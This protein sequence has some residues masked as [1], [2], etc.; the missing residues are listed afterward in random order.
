MVQVQEVQAVFGQ[1]RCQ[2]CTVAPQGKSKLARLTRTILV[3]YRT[4]F[5]NTLFFF[6]LQTTTYYHYHLD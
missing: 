6:H 2:S 3:E 5:P 1:A 4:S